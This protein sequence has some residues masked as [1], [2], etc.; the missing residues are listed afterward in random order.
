MDYLI[1]IGIGIVAI[2]LLLLRLMGPIKF[3]K[4]DVWV[5]T[6]IFDKWKQRINT[7]CDEQTLESFIA[8]LKEYKGGYIR[9]RN[10]KIVEH[11][12]L[13]K[14]KGDLK[15]I[16]YRVV[17]PSR[18]ISVQQKE[19]FRNYLRQIGVEG[20]DQRPDYELRSGKLR[21]GKLQTNK[22]DKEEYQ[23]KQAGNRGEQRV[24]DCLKELER[25][26]FS[27]INGVV[28]KLGDQIKEFD[29]IVI[30]NY[31]LFILE[32]KAFGMSDTDEGSD[33][34]KLVIDDQGTWTLY[35]YNEKRVLKDP[36]EQ[37][38]EQKKFMEL[39]LEHYF[40]EIKP[41]LVLGNKKLILKKYLDTAYSVVLIDDL[42][43]YLY[44]FNE[45]MSFSDRMRIISIIDEH[46]IN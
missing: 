18:K 41:V 1:Y 35:K 46:R 40:F 15:G 37:I 28:L 12:F 6:G 5:D 30:S 33:E 23:R 24:R 31:G 29:H 36:T 2:L 42:I 14:E 7:N 10:G 39:L 9:R 19:A 44:Q 16:F 27:V 17:K 4:K 25:D 13:G 20:M 8:F 22:N 34:A 32:T 38:M 45:K 21:S 26:K 3:T 43:T 11:S